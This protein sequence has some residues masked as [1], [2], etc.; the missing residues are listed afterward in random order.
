MLM[1]KEINFWIFSQAEDY[2]GLNEEVAAA[3]AAATA[4]A[5]TAASAAAGTAAGES[6]AAD[7]LPYII[8]RSGL[9]V[10][11]KVRR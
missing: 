4:A 8:P 10:K 9:E 11:L 2:Y 6:G 1:N 7:I 3:G 5:G